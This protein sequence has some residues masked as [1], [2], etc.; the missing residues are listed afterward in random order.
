MAQKPLEVSVKISANNATA[1]GLKAA[2]SAI[3]KNL[4]HQT[5]NATKA[6]KGLDASWR[7]VRGSISSASSALHSMGGLMGGVGG[8]LGIGGL[9]SG[10]GI[11][12]AL[13]SGTNSFIERGAQIDKLNKRLGLSHELIGEI[14]YA[15]QKSGMDSSPL[16][17]GIAILEKNLYALT[18][19][20]G[21]GKLGKFLADAGPEF[22][23]QL[24]G[25][26]V[27][28]AVSK[29]FDVLAK[30]SDPIKRMGLAM[31]ALEIE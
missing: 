7:G 14:Q 26:D 10:A 21:G 16:V 24:K 19:E 18:H 2:S 3:E 9:L 25:A 4:I 6:A 28:T 8:A 12:A 1:A 27:N 23:K 22:L 31:A 17:K 29:I 20:K 13:V 15:A 5:S 11:G 30:E